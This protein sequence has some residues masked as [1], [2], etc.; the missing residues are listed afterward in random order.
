MSK[1]SPVR[2]NP[3]AKQAFL[4]PG[5]VVRTTSLIISMFL[6]GMAHIHLQFQITRMNNEMVPLQDQQQLLLS[7]INELRHENEALQNPSGL[8]D[9][10]VDELKL[11]ACAPDRRQVIKFDRRTYMRYALH[12]G[13][14]RSGIDNHGHLEWFQNLSEQMGWISRAEAGD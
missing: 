14:Q 2:Q 13:R 10:A 6:F 5:L 7:S 11:E 12:S 9:Y 3:Q 4:A 8:Y 1:L